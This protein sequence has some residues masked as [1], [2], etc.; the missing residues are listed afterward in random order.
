M[1][2]AR[3]KEIQEFV[4]LNFGHTQ[5]TSWI[6]HSKEVHGLSPKIANYRNDI[7]KRVYPCPIEKQEDIRKAFQH[8]GMI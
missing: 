2:M 4:K 6:A 7:N 5:K 3:Y 8:F 1:K